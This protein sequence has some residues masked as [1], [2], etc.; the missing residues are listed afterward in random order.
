MA[1]PKMKITIP[2][3]G[4]DGQ[5][6]WECRRKCGGYAVGDRRGACIGYFPGPEC[7]GP[8]VYEVIASDELDRLR[9]EVERLRGLLLKKRL[10]RQF[11]N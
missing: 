7:P 5:C 2:E 1:T 3:L 9:A 8:G 6:D 11:G 4:P 10:S